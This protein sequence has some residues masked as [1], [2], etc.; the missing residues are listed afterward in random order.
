MDRAINTKVEEVSHTWTES[1]NTRVEE[2]SHTWTIGHSHQHQG[3]GGEES[4]MDIAIN[5]KV[6]EVRS[7]TWTEPS[8]PRWRR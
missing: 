5:T 3:G 6:E 7:H 2:V 8:T 4:Y 1:I